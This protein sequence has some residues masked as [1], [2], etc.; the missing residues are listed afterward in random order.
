[1]V[2]VGGGIAG[3]ALALVLARGGASVTVLERQRSYADRVR[4][5]YM[6][7]WGVAEAQRLRVLDILVGA[8]GVFATRAIGYDESVPSDAAEARARDLTTLIPG[9]PGGLGVG[10]PA[11]CRALSCAA[12]AAGARYLREASSVHIRAGALPAV[13]FEQDGAGQRMRC[14]LIVGADG[15]HS[16]TRSQAGIPFR[17]AGPTHLFSGMLVGK[18]PEWR[19][20]RYATASE[21]DIQC[22]IFPQGDERVRLYTSTALDQRHRYDGASEGRARFLDDVRRTRCL[23]LAEALARGTPIGPCATFGGED[24]WVDVPFVEGVVLIGDAAGYNNP[25]IGQGLSLALRDARAL[26]E[27]LLTTESWSPRSLWPYAEERRTRAERVRFTAGLMATL[28]ASF[29]PEAAGRRQRFL[30]RLPDADSRARTLLTS[31]AIGPE[32]S[33]AWAYTE[34]FRQEVLEGAT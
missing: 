33:P 2:I 20:D 12:E 27:I 26:S 8:G 17:T 3:S 9:V 34:A 19:Q 29:G 21:D 1:M 11:A 28:Y 15:R 7:P 25:L 13:A 14:R 31:V 5:E 6:H 18:V 4:G 32:R 30:R 22:Q 16:T 10:H 23:P 24:T